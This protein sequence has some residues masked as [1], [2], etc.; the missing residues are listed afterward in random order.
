MFGH[1]DWCL[2]ISKAIQIL[3]KQ[4]TYVESHLKR[5]DRLKFFGQGLKDFWSD[6]V[7]GS[8]P[9]EAIKWEYSCIRAPENGTSIT[10]SGRAL[11]GTPPGCRCDP[12]WRRTWVPAPHQGCFYWDFLPWQVRQTPSQ[13]CPAGRKP[14]GEASWRKFFGFQPWP[15]S[16]TDRET[17]KL[18]IRLFDCNCNRSCWCALR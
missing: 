16:A 4:S 18:E 15:L 8:F 9:I 17:W 12:C 7:W 14:R 2:D 6:S 5:P 10:L 11:W 1:F 13:C 3:S